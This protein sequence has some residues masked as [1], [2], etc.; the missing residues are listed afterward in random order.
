MK[1]ILFLMAIAIMLGISVQSCREMGIDPW[2]KGGNGGGN[3]GGDP[4]D[5]TITDTP[6]EKL[7]GT[8]WQLVTISYST[9]NE[10]ATVPND[11]LISLNF[12]SP[13]HATGMNLCTGYNAMIKSTKPGDIRFSVGATTLPVCDPADI[14][15]EYFK[16]LN[17]ATSY[18]VI[19]NELR[20]NYTSVSIDAAGVNT[21][22]SNTLIFVPLKSSTD[23]SGGGGT[24][25]ADL[26]IKQLAGHTYTLHSFVNAY[27]EEVLSNSGSC[28]LAIGATNTSQKGIAAITADCNSGTAD[29]T[30]G[31]DGKTIKFDNIA[32]T[33]MA[34]QNQMTADRY[35]QFL[36]NTSTFELS[37]YGT[38][39]TIWSSLNSFAES[40]MVM[41]VVQTP[42]VDPSIIEIQQTSSTGVP[43]STYPM[44]YVD[45]LKFDGKYI[46][47]GYQY[48]N[49][50]T[51]FKISAY[52]LL[53]FQNGTPTSVV[54][55]LV[56]DGTPNPMN[57]LV[58]GQ[59]LLSLDAIRKRILIASPNK[60][61]IDVRLRWSGQ[62]L[63]VVQV[64]L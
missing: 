39:I 30:F 38:T 37:D 18:T 19:N 23:G 51:D 17:S 29:V 61:T 25:D 44:F 13:A 43:A 63:G 12:D 26:T 60:T 36:K 2:D 56:T 55:D 1:R 53:Q 35:M 16:G 15:Q 33:E 5:S 64:L 41:K 9:R 48:G 46:N 49:L 11:K 22:S 52:S 28:S 27:S 24:S 31:Q 50:T 45:Y 62:E 58:K 54:V 6:I 59:A 42:V 32:I 8:K 57:S 10:I 47:I 20:I 34:C 3:G 40:K 7:V 21:S 14:H 4:I